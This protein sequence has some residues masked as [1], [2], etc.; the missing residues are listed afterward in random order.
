MVTKYLLVFINT[1]PELVEA[2][3]TTKETAS[4]IAKMLLEDIIPKYGLPT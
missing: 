3:P 4:I 1:F 2:Y